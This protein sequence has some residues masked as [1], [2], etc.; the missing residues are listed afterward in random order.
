MLKAL[1][2]TFLISSIITG[3]VVNFSL[4]FYAGDFGD[5]ARENFLVFGFSISSFLAYS[6]AVPAAARLNGASRLVLDDR[7]ARGL[8]RPGDPHGRPPRG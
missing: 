3:Y 4:L 6:A 5:K 2:L 7:A 1:L 8:R